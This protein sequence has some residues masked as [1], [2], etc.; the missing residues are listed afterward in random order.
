MRSSLPS[1]EEAVEQFVAQ[2][3]SAAPM[4]ARSFAAGFP[5]LGSE[6]LD[7]LVAA[8]SVVGAFARDAPSIDSMLPRR[9]GP[10]S[11]VREIA[12]G[13]MGL[14]VEAIEEPLG[15]RVALKLLPADLVSS[16]SARTR[17]QREAVLAARIEHPGVCQVFAA[18]VFD[19]RPWIAMRFVDG[20]TLS[21][22][23]RRARR[24]GE[25]TVRLPGAGARDTPQAVAACIARVARA[26]EAAHAQ[27]VVHRDVKPSNV[28]IEPSGE[29]VLL[30]FGI[31]L[32]PDSSA[33]NLTRT[34]ET[35]GT[36]AYLAPELLAGELRRSDERCDVYSLGVTLYECLAL[37][38]PFRAPT[39]EALCAAVLSGA[40]RSV[41][42][43]E[44]SIPRD[45]V[46][47]VAT[48]MERDRERRY[49]SAAALAADLEAFVAGRPI[50]ARP[51][52]P[53]GVF[54]RWARREPRQALLTALVALAALGAATVGGV[55]LASRQEIRDGREARLAAE[56]EAALFEGF[57]AYGEMRF[58]EAESSFVRA[59]ELEPQS[60]DA[61]VGRVLLRLARGR[62]GE[63][64][65]LLRD[66]PTSPA[67]D[68]LR[69]M[70][71][72]QPPLS[73][74]A[75]WFARASSF[76]LFI[77]GDRHLIEARRRPHSERADWARAAQRRFEN[78]IA[79]AP[80]PRGAYHI[81]WA[82][83]AALAGDERAAR[84]ASAGLVALW[85]ESP[86]ALFQAAFSIGAFDPR[87]AKLMLERALVLDP[88]HVPS[89]VNLGVA[90][91]ALGEQEQACATL[92]RAL[93]LDPAR[94][95]AL[96]ALADC[97]YE[98]GCAADARGL[99]MR[100]LACKPDDLWVWTRMQSVAADAHSSIRA[101]QHVLELDPGLTRHRNAYA[102]ALEHLGEQ[103]AASEQFSICVAQ[104]PG[105]ASYW[106]S[107]A[108]TLIAAG[109]ADTAL[110][111][112]EV[113]RARGAAPNELAALERRAREALHRDG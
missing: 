14:V 71:R 16:P 41:D 4:G 102:L 46:V 80:R 109:H 112:L 1:V 105:D 25:R 47:I 36:P 83:A 75:D 111:A 23:I 2:L 79:R 104:D 51:L 48:A 78:A 6:L 43:R 49:A 68:G 28:M 33:S 100:A 44:P 20:E 32:E 45:L 30:D 65:E 42:E 92:E 52:G 26:L 22:H 59:L 103:R 87:A 91:A 97:M 90:H 99:L 73:A 29:P 74:D 38:P 13:G 9:V 3:S 37:Q 69:A 5:H 88:L 72:G 55:L 82:V 85:P 35:A 110:A 56:L 27:R 108:R 84:A 58:D 10:Y 34:G 81:L 54:V 62:D 12:R 57:A 53:M 93:E 107:Y 106:V 63:A 21:E 40:P 70:A 96:V 89:Q 17:L 98:R 18:S 31:A 39:R 61:R 86:R 64:L 19:A 77:D 95:E 15:R 113:A 24:G 67:F 101:A 11:V 8:Q 66:E 76:E 7:A 94:V 60:A 50:A